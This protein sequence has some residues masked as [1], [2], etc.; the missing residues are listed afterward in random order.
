MAIQTYRMYLRGRKG[1]CRENF[2][3]PQ[4]R[5]DSVIHISAS[6]AT[7]LQPQAFTPIFSRFVGSANV[8]VS[9]VAPSAGRVDFVLNVDWGSPL[10][11]SMDITIMDPP[12]EVVVGT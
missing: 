8:S 12:V 5:S 10:N 2:R 3:A 4:I 1:R 7:R 11:V 6:E 9:N